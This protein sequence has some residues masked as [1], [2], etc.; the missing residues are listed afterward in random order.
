MLNR[1]RIRAPF[2][3]ALEPLQQ[4]HCHGIQQC[5]G[6]QYHQ[7]N[8]IIV[9]V[10]KKMNAELHEKRREM[11][12]RHIIAQRRDW[13]SY[14]VL[15]IYFKKNTTMVTLRAYDRVLFGVSQYPLISALNPNGPSP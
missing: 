14:L 6:L 8:G 1:L 13:M 7:R 5:Y 9:D 12:F 4:I 2:A 3:C 15:Q 10:I 11:Q